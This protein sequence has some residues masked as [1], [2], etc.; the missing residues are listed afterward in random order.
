MEASRSLHRPLVDAAF[1]RLVRT[2]RAPLERYVRG[3]G[4]SRED[5]EEIAATAL[6][7]A[8][9]NPP[10]AHLDPEWRAWLS[11]V[12][13]NFWIDARRRREFRLVAGDGAL[14]RFPRHLWTT[15]RPRPRKR[16]R[17]A[18]RSLSCPRPSER[19]CISAKSAVSAMRRS[20]TSSP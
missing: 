17:S 4:A 15:S 5:A 18:P 19:R 12:A 8:Y 16:D 2:H 10:A 20:P 11:T 6:L 14:E 9:Q 3:L 1:D 13:R 7:R